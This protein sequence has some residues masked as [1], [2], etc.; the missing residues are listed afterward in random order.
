MKYCCRN[1]NFSIE[2]NRTCSL[3]AN[4]KR[5]MK[6]FLPSAGHLLKKVGKSYA[7]DIKTTDKNHS[8]IVV[9]LQQRNILLCKPNEQTAKKRFIV[10]HLTLCCFWVIKSLKFFKPFSYILRFINAFTSP[11]AY[12][13]SVEENG[14]RNSSGK[15]NL[16]NNHQQ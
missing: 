16:N 14:P 15:F 7:L 9:K 13:K 1:F 4:K 10:F 5:R 8:K 3:E 6:K 12:D 11:E 2:E